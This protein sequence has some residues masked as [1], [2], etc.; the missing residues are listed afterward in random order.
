MKM[1]GPIP[2]EAGGQPCSWVESKSQFAKN[3]SDS[4]GQA[5]KSL[6]LTTKRMIYLM[7]KNRAS[8]VWW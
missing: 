6:F 1:N 8:L 5:G 2:A 7:A 4:D 3:E